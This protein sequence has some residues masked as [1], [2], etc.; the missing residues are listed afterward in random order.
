MT[1]VVPIVLQEYL[2]FPR[3]QLW[4]NF[5]ERLEEAGISTCVILGRNVGQERGEPICVQISPPSLH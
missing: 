1:C 4:K 3:I 5:A 2:P